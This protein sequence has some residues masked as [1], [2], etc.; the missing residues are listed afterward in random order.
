MNIVQ[1]IL[2]SFVGVFYDVKQSLVFTSPRP[3]YP[4]EVEVHDFSSGYSKTVDK[5]E[6]LPIVHMLNSGEYFVNLRKDKYIFIRKSGCP[7]D[8]SMHFTSKFTMPDTYFDYY[9]DGMIR[10]NRVKS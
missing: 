10:F 8:I 3:D 5:P 4:R 1:K 6:R 9:L 2:W 7:K